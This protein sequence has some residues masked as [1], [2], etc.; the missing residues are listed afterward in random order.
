MSAAP[1]YPQIHIKLTGED[2]NAFLIMARVKSAMRKAGISH[3]EIEVYTK[4]AKSGNY[5][6]LLQT[7]MN[8]VSWS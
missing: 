6:H 2:G 3:S 4:E 8:W 7:T 1:K 5:D